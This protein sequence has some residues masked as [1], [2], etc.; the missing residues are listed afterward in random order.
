LNSTWK[1]VFDL[2]ALE[3]Y[4]D[5]IYEVIEKNGARLVIYR[6]VDRMEQEF[7][8]KAPE[9]TDVIKQFA[10]LIRRLSSLKMPGGK[11]LLPRL[12]SYVKAAPYLWLLG[13]H[14]KLTMA[15]YAERF[16]N[17]LLKSFFDSGFRELSFLALAFSLAWMS[18]GNAGYPIGGSPKLIGLVEE[19]YRKLGGAIRFGVKVE[20]IIVKNGKAVGVALAGGEEIAADIVVSA[21]DGYSTIFQLL[22]GEFLSDEIEKAYKT[23]LPFPSYVQVSMGVGADLKGEPGFLGLSLDKGIQVDPETLADFLPFRIFNFDPTFAPKGKTAV[24]CFIATSNHEYWVS[25]RQADKGQYNTEKKRIANEVIRVFEERFPASKGAIEVV[26]V[27]TPATVIRYTGNW[28]GSMEG[29]LMTPASGVRQLPLTLPRLK[30]F[31]MV[32]QWVSPGGGLPSGLL[33]AR[34]AARMICRNNGMKFG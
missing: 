20:K 7:L 5:S 21:A 29:W 9:D 13:K 17:P 33:T 22:G 6:N 19:Q 31:Y 25:L 11:H 1:E 30:D 2:D 26:D 16:K 8:A 14:S 10:K 23:Y 3:F 24:T 27:A 4:Y 15:E 18:R 34:N 32:G 28:R 12:L